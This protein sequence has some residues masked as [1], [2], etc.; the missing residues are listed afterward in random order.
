M[1]ICVESDLIATHFSQSHPLSRWMLDS[2]DILPFFDLESIVAGVFFTGHAILYEK[3][4]RKNKKKA[5]KLLLGRFVP[6]KQVK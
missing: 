3:R 1:E 4:R 2:V 6:V 5:Y